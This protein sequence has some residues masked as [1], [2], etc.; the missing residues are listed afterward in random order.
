MEKDLTGKKPTFRSNGSGANTYRLLVLL[1]LVLGS[2][3]VLRA[4][5]N[6]QIRSPFDP[7]PVPTRTASSFV[8]EAEARF[9]AGD[10]NG[11]I[12]AYQQATQLEPQNVQLWSKMAQIQVY[13]SNLLTTDEE[14]RTRLQEALS[15]INQ[16]VKVAPD[17]S[18]AHAIRAF[19]LDWNSN[20]A[21]AG[22]QSDALLSQAEQEAVQALQLDNQNTL[23]LAYYAEILLDQQKWM[24]ANQYIQQA[25]ERDPFLDGCTS[26]KCHRPG[27]FSR[28]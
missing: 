2:F 16:A 8:T 7:T 25:I 3:F 9:N 17:D 1:I 20:S 21:L 18:T 10:L 12:A 14:R 23:A 6:N 24:Q 27:N 4:L 26:S 28:L 13:S 15:S 19:V 5:G 22:D 11:A